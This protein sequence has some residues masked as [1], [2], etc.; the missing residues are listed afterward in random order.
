MLSR[1][2]WFA[3]IS[4]SFSRISSH[5]GKLSSYLRTFSA[6]FGKLGKDAL[7]LLSEEVQINGLVSHG[8][9]MPRR[10]PLC[11]QHRDADRRVGRA[12]GFGL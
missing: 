2:P 12:R 1:P 9:I 4:A 8:A 10:R 6:G 11:N 7:A 5:V 3:W